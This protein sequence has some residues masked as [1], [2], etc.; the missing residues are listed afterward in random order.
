MEPLDF[1]V[2]QEMQPKNNLGLDVENT[3]RGMGEPP[4][5]EEFEYKDRIDF[6]PSQKDPVE[7]FSRPGV[8]TG[9]KANFAG[10]KGNAGLN[11]GARSKGKQFHNRE[12]DSSNHNSNIFAG[13]HA[14]NS[15]PNSQQLSLQEKKQ[16]L[17]Q[18]LNRQRLQ[19]RQQAQL[20]SMTLKQ[21]LAANAR[22]QQ[23]SKIIFF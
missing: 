23:V 17:L 22:Q 8:R 14:V 13:P 21:K 19:H 12:H 9:N 7:K 6:E 16:K 20:S 11:S 10:N 3:F 5:Y 4:S 15:G 2:P 18:I 1:H